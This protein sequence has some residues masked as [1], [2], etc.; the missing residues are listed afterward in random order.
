MFGVLQAKKVTKALPSL[1]I[2]WERK[3]FEFEQKQILKASI[4]G[5]KK[6]FSLKIALKH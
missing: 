5:K 3:M 4:K 6:S 2:S 1:D